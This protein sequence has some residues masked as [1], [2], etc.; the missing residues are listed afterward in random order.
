MKHASTRHPPLHFLKIRYLFTGM[1]NIA[2]N[3]HAV[4]GNE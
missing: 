2:I 3:M 4:G 1:E